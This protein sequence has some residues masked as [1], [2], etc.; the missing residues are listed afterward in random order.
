MHKNTKK[1]LS[2][3]NSETSDKIELDN[4]TIFESGLIE[5]HDLE[6]YEIA[7]NEFMETLQKI[8]RNV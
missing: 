3:I 6:N 1:Q 7:L 5:G 4:I 2:K 8:R